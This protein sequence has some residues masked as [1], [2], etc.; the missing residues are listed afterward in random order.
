[1]SRATFLRYNIVDDSE[2]RNAMRK[3]EQQLALAKMPRLEPYTPTLPLPWRAL[4]L[5]DF[6]GPSAKCFGQSQI[7]GE[8][9]W[10]LMALY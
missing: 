9:S 5:F 10:A 6:A 2:K 4:I 7:P 3:V 8:T 1:M